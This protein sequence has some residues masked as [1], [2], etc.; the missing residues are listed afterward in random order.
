MMNSG[1]SP[2]DT[3]HIAESLYTQGCISYPRTE[4]TAYPHNFDFKEALLKQVNDRNWG[5]I[6]QEVSYRS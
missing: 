3:M 4:T 1:S 2:T 5:A 6:V